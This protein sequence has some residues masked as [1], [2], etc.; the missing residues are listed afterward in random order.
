MP[1][2][3]EIQWPECNQVR[4]HHSVAKAIEILRNAPRQVEELNLAGWTEGAVGPALFVVGPG[5]LRAFYRFDHLDK[6]TDKIFPVILAE[7]NGKTFVL[8]GAHRLA[9]WILLK[10]PSIQ[11]VRLNAAESKSCIRPGMEAMVAALKLE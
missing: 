5:V 7:V 8:D 6:V 4:L 1:A 9:K 10:R 3:N 2:S 11:I